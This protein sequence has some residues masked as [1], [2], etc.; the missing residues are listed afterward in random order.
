ML[1]STGIT[2]N[3]L[4]KVKPEIPKGRTLPERIFDQNNQHD[5]KENNDDILNGPDISIDN[6]ETSNYSDNFT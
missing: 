2:K 3:L 4:R 1:R 6:N 5:E